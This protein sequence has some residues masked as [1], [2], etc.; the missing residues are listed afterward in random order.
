MKKLMKYLLF[1]ILFV[2]GSCG[3]RIV[4][5][6]DDEIMTVSKESLSFDANGGAEIVFV[7]TYK[8]EPCGVYC[9]S[10]ISPLWQRMPSSV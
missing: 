9:S 4:G 8:S 7:Q 3:E 2:A 6:D 1:A 10:S 5:L